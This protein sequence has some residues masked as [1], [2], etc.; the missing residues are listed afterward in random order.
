MPVF[1]FEFLPFFVM[2]LD[3]D[4]VFQKHFL[5][6]AGAGERVRHLQGRTE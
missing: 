1:I 4:V 2:K 6:L 5:L 3:Q